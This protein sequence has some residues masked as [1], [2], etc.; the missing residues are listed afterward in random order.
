MG[1]DV[2]FG[3]GVQD[4]APQVDG[5]VHTGVTVWHHLRPQRLCVCVCC[6]CV[7][8]VCVCLCVCVVCVVCVVYACVLCMCVLGMCCVC[9]C[10]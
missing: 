1:L 4:E 8:W 5:K 10:V 7:C 6:A 3:L 2:E 9:M